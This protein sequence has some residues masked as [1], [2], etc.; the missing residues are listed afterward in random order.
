VAHSASHRGIY[1][2]VASA[3]EN[4]T[5]ERIGMDRVQESEVLTRCDPGGIIRHTPW[6]LNITRDERQAAI[7]RQQV[8]N[9]SKI[10][11][12][13]D[14]VRRRDRQWQRDS[15][16]DHHRYRSICQKIVVSDE[17]AR[18]AIFTIFSDAALVS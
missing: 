5:G 13:K 17:D 12:K 11:D 9:I 1:S 18:R 4:N 7:C 6:N 15:R 14:E 10:F 16:P 8:A 3:I 2:P